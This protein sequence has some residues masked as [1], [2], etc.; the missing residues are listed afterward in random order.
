MSALGVVIR[1]ES[2][3]LSVLLRGRPME[4]ILAKRRLL[5]MG[6]LDEITRGRDHVLPQLQPHRLRRARRVSGDPVGGDMLDR[7]SEDGALGAV[8]IV[9]I[10]HLV[11]IG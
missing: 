2:A 4:W 1:A 10:A 11:E 5:S 9:G 8:G 7:V 6:S 3:R